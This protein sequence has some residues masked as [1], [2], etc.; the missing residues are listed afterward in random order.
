MPMAR[1]ETLDLTRDGVFARLRMR[2]NRLL[3]YGSAAMIGSAIGSA[4][5]GLVVKQVLFQ[6]ITQ[7]V[8]NQMQTDT[9]Q[10]NTT[11][12][13]INQTETIPNSSKQMDTTRTM[14]SIQNFNNDVSNQ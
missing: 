6:N 7:N 2:N 4:V 11:Q 12:N 14:N 8:S 10:M 9:A 5:G 13:S 3:H 1:G